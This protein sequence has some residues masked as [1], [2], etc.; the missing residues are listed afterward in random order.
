M[1]R[2]SAGLAW[3]VAVFVSGCGGG[4]NGGGQAP[5]PAPAPQLQ[6]AAAAGDTGRAPNGVVHTHRIELRNTGNAAARAVTVSVSPDAQALQL[7]LSCESAGCTSRGDGGV[8]IAE[9]PAGATV[10]LNQRLRVKPGYRGALRNEW[11]AGA[12]GLSASWRQELTAYVADLSVSVGAPTGAAAARNYEVTLTNQGPDEATDVSWNLLTLP[13]QSWRISSCTAS[14]GATCPASLGEAMTLARLPANAALKLQVQMDESAATDPYSKGL[15]SRADAAGD[16]APQDNEAKVGQ[17]YSEHQ[18]MTDLA[19][20]HYRLAIGIDRRLRATAPGVDYRAT[21]ALDVTGQAFIG[22]PAAINPPWGRGTVNHFGPVV[23]L[24]LDIDGTRKLYVSPHRLISELSELEGVSFNVLGSRADA[25]GKAL[26]AYAGSARFKD[27]ALQLCLP[28]TPTP[29]NQCPAAR[30][31]RFEAA[32]VGSEIELVSRDKTM[33]LR[34]ARSNQ[35]PILISS[36]RDASTDAS[37]FWIGLPSDSAYPFRNGDITMYESTFESA[38]G[39]S[40]AV[41]AGI[42][43]D[44]ASNPRAFTPSPLML[45][46]SVFTRLNDT[47]LLG[48]CGLSAQASTTAQPGLFQ[49]ELRGDWLPGNLQ[50]NQFVKDKPCFAS[51]PV[52]HAQTLGMAVFVGARGGELMGRWMFAGE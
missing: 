43:S 9:I 7:P 15:G 6:M 3:G 14:T 44:G 10:L 27:G 32:L 29:F 39:L 46:S 25:S 17:D 13:G 33:R 30:L 1:R 20:R 52:L 41:F 31:S 8:D 37:E 51:G 19:G 26:D 16:P 24:G 12:T 45:P 38:S 23:V 18:F 4:G 48:I 11:Q 35:G 34:A 5:V 47:G 40:T 2:I 22:D 49:A 21:Y 28:D 50:N 42:D 36:S